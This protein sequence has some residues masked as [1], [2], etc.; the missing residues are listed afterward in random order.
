MALTRIEMLKE[1]RCWPQAL[2]RTAETASLAGE[3]PNAV[4]NDALA[5]LEYVRTCIVELRDHTHD[6]NDDDYCDICGADGRA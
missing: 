5:E 3:N 4:Y 2:A 1:L 6:W